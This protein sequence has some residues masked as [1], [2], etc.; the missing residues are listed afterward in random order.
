MSKDTSSPFDAVA[1]GR[2]EVLGTSRASAVRFARSESGNDEVLVLGVST[3]VSAEDNTVKFSN[4]VTEING[5]RLIE[6]SPEPKS[7]KSCF[8]SN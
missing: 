8:I 7:G 6:P 1:R 3:R 4:A 2:S 5:E